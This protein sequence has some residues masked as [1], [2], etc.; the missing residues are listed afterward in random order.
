MLETKES[1]LQNI[2][3]L[4]ANFSQF[5]SGLDFSLK[6]SQIYNDKIQSLTKDCPEDLALAA[7][8]GLSRM[9]LS[10]FSDIDIIF[11][12]NSLSLIHI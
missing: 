8:G 7:I 1:F 3:R 12:T 2:N 11:I 6:L 5:N 4:I 9:E 10:P